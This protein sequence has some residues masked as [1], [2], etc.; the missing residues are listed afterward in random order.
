MGLKSSVRLKSD[1]VW[2]LRSNGHLTHAL[3]V[4]GATLCDHVSGRPH[5]EDVSFP[6]AN[7]VA[8]FADRKELYGDVVPLTPEG[9]EQGRA[10][11]P[12]ILKE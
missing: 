3:P 5:N 2:R 8:A 10:L 7:K 11:P 9:T 6:L 4:L 1:W 12:S